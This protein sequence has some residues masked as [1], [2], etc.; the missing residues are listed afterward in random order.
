MSNRVKIYFFASLRAKAGR[1]DIFLDLDEG[2]SV[3]DLKC[4]VAASFP[5]IREELFRALVA[6]NREYSGDEEQ[7]PESAEIAIF[8][9]VSGG[10][11][12]SSKPTFCRVQNEQIAID[13]WIGK[14]IT[15]TAGAI[16]IFVGVVRSITQGLEP[17]QTDYL[18]YE[19]Y[20][21]MAEMKILQ[22]ASEIRERW[23]NIEGIAIIQR[24]GEIKSGKPSV[25]IACCAAHRDDGVFDAAHYGI[26][27]LKEIVPVWKRET[28]PDGH[29]WIEGEYKPK[30][31][32]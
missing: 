28:R 1:Q 7:I 19:A 26:D 29:V 21:P 4:T 20:I 16:G 8:P 6:V 32:E 11:G 25:F 30:P 2:A 24:Y 17:Y 3:Y 14:I 5:E 12:I 22:I 10:N 31:G 9:P 13:E 27:R 18:T 23:P 15:P